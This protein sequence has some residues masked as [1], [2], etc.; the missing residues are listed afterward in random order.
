M[1][2]RSVVINNIYN[3]QVINI[4]FCFIEEKKPFTII[5]LTMW[6]DLL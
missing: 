6:G 4:Q 2:R 3:Q 1:L 5:D